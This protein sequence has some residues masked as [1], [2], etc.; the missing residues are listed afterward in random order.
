MYSGNTNGSKQK[1]MNHTI[2][3]L[4]NVVTRAFWLRYH[5]LMT[6]NKRTILPVVYCSTI[7]GVAG[8]STSASAHSSVASTFDSGGIW[9]KKR[10]KRESNTAPMKT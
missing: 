10:K 6:L 2:I 7:T 4:S 5:L 1:T 9:M 8:A 3:P